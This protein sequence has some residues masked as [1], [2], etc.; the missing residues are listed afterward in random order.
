M[1]SSVNIITWNARGIK[2]KT[3][4]FF[5]FL[6]SKNIH[7]C[8]LSETWLKPNIALSHQDFVIY[9]KDRTN[10]NGG[11]VA[12]VIKKGISHSLIS[13][14]N[15]S[16][17]ENIGL[18]IFTSLGGI[19]VYACYFPGGLTG[20]SGLR[21]NMFISDLHK[22]CRSDQF[23]LGGDFNSR[24]QNW[25]C[26]RANSWGNTLVCKQNSFNFDILYPSDHTYIPSQINHQSSTLDLFITNVSQ[27][28]SL[29]EV[30]NGLGSDHLPVNCQLMSQAIKSNESYRDFRKAKWT[31][32]SKFINKNLIIP[33]NQAFSNDEFIDSALDHFISTINVAIE[34]SV[35]VKK[36][37]A[38]KQKIPP[39]IQNLIKERN[40]HRRQWI[41]YRFTGDFEKVKELNNIINFEIEKLRNSSWNNMLSSLDKGSSPFWNLTKIF[42]KKSN[43]I[44][45]LSHNNM[46]FS[47]ST[48]KCEVLAQI[49]QENHTF[50]ENLSDPETIN[51]VNFSITNFENSVSLSEPIQTNTEDILSIIKRLKNKKSPGSDG[52]NNQCLKALPKKGLQF[53]AQLFNSCLRLGY[54]PK[55]FKVA[56]VIAIK[57][58]NKQ[59][60]SP[61]SYRPISL[62]SSIS[63][64]LEKV[65]KD[66]ILTY[67]ENNNILPPQQFGF[68]KEHNTM[69]P[70]LRIRNLVKSNFSNQKSTGMILLDI[71]AA[72]D[73][74]WHDGLIHKLISLKFNDNIIKI[75]QSFLSLRSFR[76][77]I[78]DKAS[79][80]YP[81]KAGCPQGSCLSPILYNI[82][83]FDIP[84]INF[85]ETSIFADDTAI[86]C[87]DI[88]ASD[89]IIKL[90]EALRK[91]HIYFNKWK[92][93][94]NSE[95]TQAIYFTRKRVERFVPQRCIS[96]NNQEIKW[97]TKVKYLGVILDQ[98]LT[99]KEH[100]SYIISKSNVLIKSL[101]PFINKSSSLNKENKM[102]I[103]KS[104][105]HA[106]IFYAA[107]I[108]AKS[109]KCHLKKLQVLQ[110][111][112]LK[113]IFNKPRLFST[114]RLHHIA[115]IDVVITKIEKLTINFYT[116][117]SYSVY[118]IIAELASSLI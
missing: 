59:S 13:D 41:R 26:L 78:G 109:A 110:N 112:L 113:L 28:I 61:S 117:C 30:I 27:H 11:G 54:F 87:S 32:F 8:L 22:L 18:K 57:K 118:D 88:L 100:I 34:H 68:R 89:I 74:V 106:V 66:K 115:E 80:I 73:S 92:I 116:K 79:S 42:K 108:W 96:F 39:T 60:H 95:K 21:K 29:P 93:S 103:F 71:K 58:P 47:T 25:G 40:H 107:P 114:A 5:D 23:I 4:E 1:L 7:A 56:K 16:V 55:Q 45:I 6:I 52:I 20:R 17:I 10:K 70:L 14:V 90:E 33:P 81:I 94:L 43:K 3:I 53:L 51:N 105:F 46:R 63:K 102:L 62:L 38:T 65:I 76:V 9:R 75:I 12:I 48:E 84:K 77:H 86:L 69:H 98:K 99:F 67:V 104:I 97:E 111:K 15:T 2:N 31:I 91:L 50:S 37:K 49:F 24:H 83:T 35:P 85:C 101:Y 44:P 82:Y 19:N 72:F 64:I 36:L